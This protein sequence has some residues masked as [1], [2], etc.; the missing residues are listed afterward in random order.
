MKKIRLLSTV[1]FI[2]LTSASFAQDV[3][4]TKDSKKIN[5]KVTEVNIN[6]IKYIDFDNQDGAVFTLLKS[7][8]VS[9]VYQNGQVE[10]FLS[11]SSKSTTS[12][13]TES[14]SNKA[15]QIDITSITPFGNIL[16][17]M[18]TYSPLIYSKYQSGEKMRTAGMILSGLGGAMSLSGFIMRCANDYYEPHIYGVPTRKTND[19]SLKRAWGMR[20]MV[21]GGVCIVTGVPLWIV[22]SSKKNR[23]VSDFNKQ[24]YLLQQPTPHFQLNMHPNGIGLAYVF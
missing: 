1:C 18:K 24:N 7:D 22:G 16:A 11:E 13:Q 6:N 19:N 4:V 20:L 9:I 5:A 15:I 21:A 3:I 10:T 14:V 2:V 8:I 23:A 17:D 12:N